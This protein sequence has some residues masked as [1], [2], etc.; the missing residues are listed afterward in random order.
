MVNVQP[1][2]TTT[3]ATIASFTVRV[4]D[5]NLFESATLYVQLF[6]ADGV[7]LSDKV[8]QMSG[9]DYTSWGSD[10]SYINRFVAN[11]LGATLA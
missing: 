8:I 10:D 2:T 3:T 9:S 1:Y 11:N 6:D 5:I 7:F 4:A